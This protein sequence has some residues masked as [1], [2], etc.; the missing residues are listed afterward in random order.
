FSHSQVVS[1]LS[2]YFVPVWLSNDDYAR[3]RKTQAE[4]DEVRRIKTATAR[5]GLVNGNVNVYLID[6]EGDIIDT[7]GVAKALEPGNL[8]PMLRKVVQ[9]KQLQPRDPKA[10]RASAHPVLPAPDPQTER[11]LVL[12]VW[13]RF[14]PPGETEKGSTDDFVELT[15]EEWAGFVP[16]GNV[17]PGS[18]W[19]VPRKVADQV[20]QYFYPAV[21]HYDAKASKVRGGTLTATV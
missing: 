5:K 3:P 13:T 4:I 2:Q 8:L 6:P 20:S 10:V 1:L 9:A 11:G 15:A 12:H 18:S 17:K 14:L 21:C 7:M 16:A 19:E